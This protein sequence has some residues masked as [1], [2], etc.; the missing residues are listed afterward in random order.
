MCPMI[1][2][3]MFL[4]QADYLFGKYKIAQL[5]ISSRAET[6]KTTSILYYY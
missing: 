1:W 4:P 6:V 5:Q 3:V 2:V